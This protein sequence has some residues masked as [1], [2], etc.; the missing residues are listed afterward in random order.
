MREVLEHIHPILVH[1]PIALF[2]SAL[3]IEILSWCLK[4][5]NLHKTALYVYIFATLSAPFSV[6][7]GWMEWKK[8]NIH[9]PILDSH[10]NFGFALMYFSIL[11]LVF[12]AT[13][14]DK[15]FF[16]PLFLCLL[17][18]MA[19]LVTITA[20]FGGTMV[21]EYGVGVQS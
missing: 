14:K 3:G 17:L 9:H 21:Y 16:P 18:I 5:S 15:K 10:R 2:I 11:G 8:L 6:L 1:F 12:V 7:T 19:V 13:C 4:S 20:Y